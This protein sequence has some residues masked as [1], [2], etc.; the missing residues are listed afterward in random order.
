[1]F[2]KL[3]PADAVAGFKALGCIKALVW[4]AL[5]FR[6]WTEKSD[7]VRVPT[8]LLRSWGVNRKTWARA[9]TRLERAGLIQ[10]ER[11][12]GKSV[13]CRLLRPPASSRD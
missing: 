10:T 2:V 9:L 11:R 7:T 12:H 4:Y 8:A 5:L 6:A 13:V 3:T 1:L